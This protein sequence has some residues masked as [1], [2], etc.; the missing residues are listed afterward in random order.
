LLRRYDSKLCMLDGM[1]KFFFP[2]N[3]QYKAPRRRSCHSVLRT[4]I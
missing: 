2:S 4:Y 3:I 1:K